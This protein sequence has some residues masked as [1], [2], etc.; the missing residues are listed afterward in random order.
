MTMKLPGGYRDPDPGMSLR[1][2]QPNRLQSDISSMDGQRDPDHGMSPRLIDRINDDGASRNIDPSTEDLESRVATTAR[3]QYRPVAQDDQMAGMEARYNQLGQQPQRGRLASLL[4]K[5][6]TIASPRYERYQENQQRNAI[7]ERDSLLPQITA[8]RRMESRS[9]I[10]TPAPM[11]LSMAK[12][13]A[14]SG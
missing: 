13:S 1:P 12:T 4:N 14:I 11:R 8:Q 10:S 2:R 6:A 5:V 9:G 3:P 7:T